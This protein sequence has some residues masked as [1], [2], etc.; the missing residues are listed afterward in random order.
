MATQLPHPVASCAECGAVTDNDDA[1]NARCDRMV[2]GAR[3]K[4]AYLSRLN[5]AGWRQCPA[6]SATGCTVCGGIGW[7]AVRPWPRE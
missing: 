3:C 2:K 4:G 1:I 6:C 7:F 5:S